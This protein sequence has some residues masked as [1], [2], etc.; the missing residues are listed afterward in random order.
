M[1]IRAL[2]IALIGSLAAPVAAQDVAPLE[3]VSI[4]EG[5]Q[6][7]AEA[8]ARAEYDAG[9]A[10][11]LSGE[12]DEALAHFQRAYDL[13]G[14]A[15]LLYNVGIAATNSGDE[16]T[17][18]AAFERYVAELPDASNRALVEGRM[19][20]LRE[21]I[22]EE[23]AIR[24]YAAMER[25]AQARERSAGANAARSAGV[26]MAIGGAVLVAAGAVLL[27]VGYADYAA[28]D[29]ATDGTAWTALRGAYERAPMLTGVGYGGAG[30]GLALL[31]VGLGVALGTSDPPAPDDTLS[32]TAG[33]G[34]IT[35]RGSF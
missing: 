23:E 22:E 24:R 11:Y 2:V 18:L 28:V 17:A 7:A 9:E 19:A 33:L 30:L 34:S 10:S 4:E 21:E 29:G 6:D 26:G 12:F 1:V 5:A 8:E 32:V 13:S 3:P 15:E 20:G 14:R 25:E 27:G 16:R 35:V 31:G